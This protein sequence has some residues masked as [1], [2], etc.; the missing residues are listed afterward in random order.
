MSRSDE[1][2]ARG[3]YIR[4]MQERCGRFER[5]FRDSPMNDLTNDTYVGQKLAEMVKEKVQ[6]HRGLEDREVEH[7]R[8][9]LEALRLHPKVVVIGRA[10]RGKTSLLYWAVLTWLAALAQDETAPVPI[11][12]PLKDL[13]KMDNRHDLRTYLEGRLADTR[14]TR[15]LWNC[16]EKGNVLLLLDALDEVQ[17]D[18]RLEFLNDRG[19]LADLVRAMEAPDAKI[20]LTCRDSVYGDV[21]ERLSERKRR[22]E[23]EGFVK[24]ELKKFNRDQIAA[25]AKQFFLAEAKGQ[26]DAQAQATERTGAFLRDIEDPRGRPAEGGRSSRYTH[27]AEEPLYLHML[28]WLWAGK[29]DEVP[30]K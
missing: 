8:E 13:D 10:G 3:Q 9:F 4:L 14:V 7:Q 18:K 15:W 11:F 23:P 6:G 22:G 2:Y 19:I 16:F 1:E 26:P 20:V 21:R 28:C 5:S 25:Y 24:M 29:N 30:A 27:L 17:R 12:V